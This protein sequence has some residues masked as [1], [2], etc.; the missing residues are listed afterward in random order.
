MAIGA[1]QQ[2]LI[3]ATRA[4]LAARAVGMK[5]PAQYSPKPSTQYSKEYLAENG[6]EASDVGP[7]PLYVPDSDPLGDVVRSN[8]QGQESY[9]E[10]MRRAKGEGARGVGPKGPGVGIPEDKDQRLARMGLSPEGQKLPTPESGTLPGEEQVTTRDTLRQLS[11]TEQTA[12]QR[13]FDSGGHSNTM[14]YDDWL[15]ENFG[16]LPPA[17]RAS[18]MRASS[19][20]TPRVNIGKDPYLPAGENSDLAQGR[21]AA[22]LPLPEGREAKQYSPEQL[23]AMSRNVHNPDIPMTRFGGTFTHNP[24]GALSSRAPNPDMMAQAAAIAKDQGEFSDS[25]IA[26]LAQAYG[27]DAHKYGNDLDMLR[28]DVMREKERHD[29]RAVNY[30]PVA[31]GGG[32]YRYAPNDALKARMAARDLERF[33]GDIRNR[34]QGLQG[35]INGQSADDLLA[36]VDAAAGTPNGKAEMVKLNGMLRRLREGNQ[37]Q[38][39]R[40]RA[41]NYSLS[42]DLRNP[43]QAPGMGVRSLMEAVASNNPLQMAAVHD[44]YGNPNAALQHRQLA[45]VQSQAA[46]DVAV[47][48]EEAQAAMAQQQPDETPKR[49]GEEAQAEFNTALAVPDAAQRYAAV[50][51]VV[52]GINPSLA[53]ADVAEQAQN[54]IASHLAATN[55]L[56]DPFVQHRIGMLRASKNRDAFTQFVMSIGAAK[57][58]DEALWMF[59][60]PAPPRTAEQIGA[61]VAAGAKQAAANTANAG[62]GFIRGLTGY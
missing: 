26:A 59:N 23:R 30:N 31:M 21:R 62:R 60:N 46:A 29:Q 22:G 3:R 14:S 47:A 28:G 32:A 53:D 17:E 33:A 37:H 2:S 42:Q 1:D 34:N 50:S 8:T 40:N 7:A 4:E 27:I 52:K 25:H 35:S 57:T 61:D 24:G 44:I 55:G 13:K 48:E 10:L 36:A 12:L 58:P 38:S 56:E 16:D 54:I 6:L 39:A 43:N 15:T 49:V 9:S 19:S 11:P 41:Q 51:R 5:P 18:Q 45:G 20:A